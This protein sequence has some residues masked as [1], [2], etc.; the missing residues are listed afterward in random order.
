MFW[1]GCDKASMFG[2]THLR[3][4]ESHD[5]IWRTMEP[6]RNVKD[7]V[8]AVAGEFVSFQNA[9]SCQAMGRGL[10]IKKPALIS[11]FYA[12]DNVFKFANNRS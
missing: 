10:V 5:L 1:Q 2:Q 4:G 8:V 3:G 11:T 12:A 9:F 6:H 7:A